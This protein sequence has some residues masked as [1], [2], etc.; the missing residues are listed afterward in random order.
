M[1]LDNRCWVEISLPSFSHNVKHAKRTL[2]GEALLMVAV[3]SDAYG[4]GQDMLAPLALAEGADALAVL[5]ITTGLAL[6]PLVG[7]APM[8]CWLLS[9][10]ND[11]AQAIEHSLALGVSHRWQLE[12]IRDAGATKPALVHLKIDTGLHRNGALAK[13]WP[14]L[15]E[16]AA[17]LE[18]EG[19]LSVVGIWS[20]LADTSIE[21]DMAALER[22]HLAVAQ[23]KSGGLSP[24][25]LHVAA[26]AA[27]FEVPESRLDMVRIGLI[28]YGVTPFENTSA[29][30]LGFLPVMATR[31]RVIDRDSAKHTLSIGM[32]FADGLLPLPPDTGW[33]QINGERASILQ[34][35]PEMTTVSAPPAAVSVGDIATLWGDPES[36]SPLVE[37]WALWGKTIGD[38]VISGIA[39][40]VPKVYLTHG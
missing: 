13:D 8:L 21:H 27:A 16:L 40:T 20:H 5:D 23:A 32:G 31:A 26:S 33:V 36:G 11:F 12:K 37:D 35:G 38:E 10:G 24:T 4:H 28:I 22:F 30:D 17:V 25:T 34:V 15:V 18:A 9:P 7:D 3:K 6:R 14:A 1:D 2:A 19:V 39:P 29:R